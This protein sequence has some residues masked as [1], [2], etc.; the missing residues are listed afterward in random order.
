MSNNCRF[1]A[2]PLE[3]TFADLG[4]SPISNDYIAEA[5]HNRMEP[6]YPLHA[7]VCSECRLVQLIDYERADA[8]FTDDYAYFSSFSASW[9][10]HARSYAEGAI[11]R[12]GLTADSLVVELASNDG[13][14][15]KVFKERGVRVLGVEPTANTARAALDNH[16]IESEVAFFG[17]E[18]AERLRDRGLQA[19]VMAANNVLAHVPDIND[20][21]AGYPI[22]LKDTGV[23]N[24]EFPHLLRMMEKRQFDTIYHE[25]F[26]YLSFTVVCR[27]FAAHGMRVF[28]V[29]ELGTHGGSLRIYVAHDGNTDRPMTARVDN[30]LKLEDDFGLNDLATYERFSKDVLETKHALLQFF[31]DAARE[32]KTVVGYGAPAKGNTLLNYCGVKPDM[33]PFT[34]DRS[35]HKVGK[36][37]PGTH[38]PIRSP[39]DIMAAQPDYLLILPWNLKEEVMAQMAGIRAWGGKFVTPIPLVE[40]TA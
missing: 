8:L 22:L 13:Y 33:L 10:D 26:S 3:I 9:L 16:G 14:L 25:H 30:M 20:F 1:C 18:T 39:D 34:V 17:R 2:S 5:Q 15:L 40:I 37:L 31:I 23:A 21:V 12:E 38:I 19:D 29:E 6:F 27:I 36:R 7:F 24:V 35:P 28:D 11:E 4:M 32:G